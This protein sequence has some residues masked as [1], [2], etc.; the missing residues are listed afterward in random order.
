[1]KRNC[2]D[3]NFR[4]GVGHSFTEFSDDLTDFDHKGWSINFVGSC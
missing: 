1:V 4:I 3:R 2:L